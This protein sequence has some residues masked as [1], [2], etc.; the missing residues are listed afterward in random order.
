MNGV[1]AKVKGTAQAA[2][3]VP[4]PEGTMRRLHRIGVVSPIRDPWGRRL[5]GDDDVTAAREYLA[6]RSTQQA[7]G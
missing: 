1:V 4:C 6:R 2:R 5:F 3:E 7:A